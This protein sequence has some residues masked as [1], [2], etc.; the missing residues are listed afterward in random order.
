M[1]NLGITTHDELCDELNWSL[2]HIRCCGQLEYSQ[3]WDAF[4][5]QCRTQRHKR[6]QRYKFQQLFPFEKSHTLW[7]SAAV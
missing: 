7:A 3:D 5:A 1:A 4:A 2:R 6:L